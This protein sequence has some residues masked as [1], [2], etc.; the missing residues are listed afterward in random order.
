MVTDCMDGV[1]SRLLIIARIQYAEQRASREAIFCCD[2]QIS[3]GEICGPPFVTL[4][5]T[6]SKKERKEVCKKGRKSSLSLF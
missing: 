1:G 5:V 4:S 3:E 6:V 2:R